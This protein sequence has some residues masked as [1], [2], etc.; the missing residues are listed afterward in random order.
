M[1]AAIQETIPR[2][3]LTVVTSGGRLHEMRGFVWLDRLPFC[4]RAW[5]KVNKLDFLENGLTVHTA[6]G[7]THKPYEPLNFRP[8]TGG[9]I[10]EADMLYIINGLNIKEGRIK[11]AEE[12][13]KIPQLFTVILTGK[14]RAYRRFDQRYT[15]DFFLR[16]AYTTAVSLVC[17]E[18]EAALKPLA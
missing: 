3:R 12:D 17:D 2:D 18:G 16:K 13:G 15:E 9:I 8:A 7:F 4:F 6:W 14:E 11:V 1:V 10:T 5:P